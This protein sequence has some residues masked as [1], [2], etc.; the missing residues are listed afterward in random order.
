MKRFAWTCL[1]LAAG[2]VVLSNRSVAAEFAFLAPAPG[3]KVVGCA[4]AYPNMGAERLVDGSS[5]AY[6]SN[7]KGTET[8]V[9][10]DLGRPTQIGAF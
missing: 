9:D 8:Y 3:L 1:C 5:L 10:F 7:G 6:A 4:E 2:L